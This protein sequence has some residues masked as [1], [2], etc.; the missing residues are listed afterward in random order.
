MIVVKVAGIDIGGTSIKGIVMNENGDILQTSKI[1][2]EA[3]LG[4]DHILE[5]LNKLI[6]ELLINHYDLKG[7]GIGTAGRVNVNTGEVVYATDNLKNWQGTNLKMVLEDHFNLPVMVDNDANAALIGEHWL[8]AGKGLS[9]ITMCTLGTGVGGANMV[10]RGILRGA[11]WN[12]GEWGHVIF[13]PNGRPCNCGQN[14][15]L[16]Q[17]LS[18]NALVYFAEAATNQSYLSGNNV[19]EDFKNN[20]VEIIKVVNEYINHLSTFIYNIH[21]SLDPQCIIIGGGVIDSKEIWWDIFSNSLTRLGII[22]DVRPAILGNRAG[23]VGAAK[24]I[25]DTFK[26]SK[27]LN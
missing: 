24:L 21:N 25:L 17:Y 20:R 22:V 26:K 6:G 1:D 9:N 8:G 18:G 5:N 16:E 11:N 13:I 15:C 10:N 3:V 23:S 7:I 12:G 27:A 4:R 14:G 19:M 2:T